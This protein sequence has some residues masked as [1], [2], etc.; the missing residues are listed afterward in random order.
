VTR[1]Q[2]WRVGWTT[3]DAETFVSRRRVAVSHVVGV[4]VVDG[5]RVVIVDADL[6]TTARRV[7]YDI[8]LV[9]VSTVEETDGAGD[10]VT[11]VSTDL[12]TSFF[13]DLAGDQQTRE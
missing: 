6:D 8:A 12:A 2:T 4:D 3:V 5:L 11:N 1:I 10:P 7:G 9:D 13:D